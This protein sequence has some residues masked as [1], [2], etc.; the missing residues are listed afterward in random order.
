MLILARE[1]E[2]D[3]LIG[4]DIVIRVISIGPNKVRLGITA[5]VEVSVDRREIREAKDR[6]R[7][8][9]EGGAA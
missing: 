1:L 9:R 3:V 5:P 4:D 2:Q 6:E 7:R 8:L